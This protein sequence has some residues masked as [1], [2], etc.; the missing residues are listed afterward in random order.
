MNSHRLIVPTLTL[1]VLAACTGCVHTIKIS[2]D[3]GP[4]AAPTLPCTVALSLS[5]EFT[6]CQYT[7]AASAFTDG[8]QAPFGPTMQK[9]ATIVAR[10]VFGDVRVIEGQS[11][12][13]EAKLLLI[14]RVTDLNLRAI[15][16]GSGLT[17]SGS[18]GVHWDFNNPQTGQTLFS[19]PVSC[20]SSYRAGFFGSKS[21][22]HILPMVAADLMTNLTSKTIQ[23]F[24][25]SKELQRLS[26]H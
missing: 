22:E 7:T 11:A 9:Y 24:N 1:C 5:K 4:P 3:P 13:S 21:P 16:P 26:G 17:A 15:S 6:G 12:P 25:A 19:M 14:P 10:S 8:I 23:R 20:E 2:Y 18:L